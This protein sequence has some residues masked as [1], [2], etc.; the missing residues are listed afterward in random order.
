MLALHCLLIS[1]WTTV[2]GFVNFRF[3]GLLVK[4]LESGWFIYFDLRFE[5]LLLNILFCALL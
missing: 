5:V 4:A 1:V 3:L 2:G